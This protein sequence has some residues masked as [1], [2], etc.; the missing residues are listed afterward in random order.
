MKIMIDLIVSRI[1]DETPVYEVTSL[2]EM[3]TVS[4]A[5][6]NIDR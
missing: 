5:H 3:A 1:S 2:A 4:A 6:L